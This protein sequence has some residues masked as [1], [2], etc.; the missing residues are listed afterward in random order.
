MSKRVEEFVKSAKE[1]DEMAK[2]KMDAICKLKN[3]FD[4]IAH[5][6]ANQCEEFFDNCTEDEF[7]ELLA[8]VDDCDKLMYLGMKMVKDSITKDDEE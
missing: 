3:E 2:I 7:N 5:K 8:K 6:R 4:E 1:M